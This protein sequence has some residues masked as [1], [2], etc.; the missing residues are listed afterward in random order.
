MKQTIN[1]LHAHKEQSPLIIIIMDFTKEYKN[2]KRISNKRKHA[3]LSNCSL[4]NAQQGLSQRSALTQ[5]FRDDEQQ[6]KKKKKNQT[7]LILEKIVQKWF[8]VFRKM[9][10]YSI[11]VK[12][13]TKRDETQPE[14]WT[15]L[16][17]T[18]GDQ[19]TKRAK[20]RNKR[21]FSMCVVL[22]QTD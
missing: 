12:P 2:E 20:E 21:E 7:N 3:H 10:Q 13:D 6:C 17:R 19:Y 5:H 15:F 4:T 14:Q 8:G 22:S 9:L 1:I 18:K 16:D 11:S